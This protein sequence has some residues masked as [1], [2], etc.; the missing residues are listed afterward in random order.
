VVQG[1]LTGADDYIVKP[2]NTKVLV[3]RCNNLVNS[4]KLL[5]Q[6][7]AQQPDIDPQLIATN[8]IDQQLLEKATLI[9]EKNIDNAEFDVN[10]FASEMWLS[11]TNL[12][13][14]LK[15]VTGQTPNDFIVNIRLK[16]S[17][18]LLVN[19]PELSIADITVQVGFGSTSYYI[20]KFH[21]LFGVT[22]AQYRKN[23][24]N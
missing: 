3:T 17:I 5:Q 13:N 14:K 2:F 11:R 22:P 21:K 20:K 10:A 19:N 6:K 15:G 23:G 7:F 16:K 18:Y 9:V 24:S 4:R 1:L 8:S 12:F